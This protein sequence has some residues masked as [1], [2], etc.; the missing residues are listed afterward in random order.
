MWKL[1]TVAHDYHMNFALCNF[2]IILDT[3]KITPKVIVNA[4]HTVV[5]HNIQIY[6]SVVIFIFKYIQYIIII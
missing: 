5:K 3:F 6:I 4:F 1:I 2:K